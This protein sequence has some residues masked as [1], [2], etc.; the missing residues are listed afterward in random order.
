MV[1]GA[2]PLPAAM[3]MG[4]PS[5]A[6]MGDLGDGDMGLPL[7]S[8]VTPGMGALIAGAVIILVSLASLLCGFRIS[9]KSTPGGQ[10]MKLAGE[11]YGIMVPAVFCL[12]LS[13]G[14]NILIPLFGGR[15]VASI[16]SDGMSM[17][18][19]DEITVQV[20][21]VAV[22]FSL[23]SMIRGALFN[24]AGERIICRLRK[25]VF[26]ALLRQEVA[27]LD[28]E[29]SGALVSRL[30]NDTGVLQ[31]AASTNISI[32]LRSSASIIMSAMIMFATSWK[33]TLAMLCCI[34]VASGGAII[35]SR[36]SKR[37]R[38][39]Y[40]ENTARMGK[41]AGETFGNFR[42]VMSF[43]HGQDFMC[44]KYSTATDDTYRYGRQMSWIYGAWSGVVGMLFFV[45][46]TIVLRFGAG[47]VE[48]KEMKPAEL[49]AFVLYTISL[50]GSVAFLGS[51]LPTFAAAIGA[52]ERIFEIIHREPAIPDGTVDPGAECAGSL[53]FDN[54][55]FT[56]PTRTDVEVL[57]GV[58]FKVEPNQVVALVGESGNGKST[59]VS[60]LLRLYVCNEGAVR[61]DGYDVRTLRADYLRRHVAVV[62]QEP[63]LFDMTIRENIQ[64]GVPAHEASEERMVRMAELA[65]C[66]DFIA[67][68]PEKYEV[69]VGER[70]VQ[71]SGGQKQ[72]VA[73]A[74]A[75]MAKP[76]VILLDEATSALDAESER[77][78]HALLEKRDGQTFVVVAH[79]L[80]TIRR[81]ELIIV[82]EGGAVAEMG[83]HRELLARGG[84][85]KA[86]VRRQLDDPEES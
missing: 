75:L 28:Q 34:P 19:V 49:I 6:L 17:Q 14:F 73:I 47:L 2:E 84:A 4:S 65:N 79:R 35:V 8:G 83:S 56:Y 9:R 54:V 13:S 36:I 46:F 15:F 38:K 21:V 85:Y 70:G 26:I 48:S 33:L 37:V 30:T 16:Q 22:L 43:R 10:I 23:T 81:A 63:I 74:R 5:A 55:R 31:N 59:C 66:H 41:F 72:R 78:V 40:Q 44:G 64:F 68:F 67:K 7:P 27:Y 50:S 11:E 58:T 25:Q 80:S 86:L 1:M 71:L 39:Q 76:R 42:T 52:T 61:I 57:K 62:S 69:I 24:L 60:L 53:E 45:A 18:V 29:T 12:F 51:V 82:L 32:M 3:L 77:V 20:L